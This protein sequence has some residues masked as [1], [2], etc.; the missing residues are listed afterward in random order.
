MCDVFN[1]FTFSSPWTGFGLSASRLTQKWYCDFDR[2]LVIVITHKG[3]N[4][5]GPGNLYLIYTSS[6]S[7]SGLPLC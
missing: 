4:I 6:I 3:K 5:L 7:P 2:Q 1:K